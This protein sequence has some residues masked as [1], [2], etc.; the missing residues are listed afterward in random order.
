MKVKVLEQIEEISQNAL[1]IQINT[2][3][4]HPEIKPVGG[5][6]GNQ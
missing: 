1:D 6:P 2:L 4:L 3:Y 5:S